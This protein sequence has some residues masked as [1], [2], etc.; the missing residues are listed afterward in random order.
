MIDTRATKRLKVENTS[1]GESVLSVWQ[2]F[3]PKSI[4]VIG[5]GRKRGTIG[6]DIL[7]NLVDYGFNGAVYPV[8]PNARFIQSMRAYRSVLEIPDPIDLAVVCVPK[9]L[10]LQA[11]EDCG[12]KDVKSLVM[13]TAGFSETGEAGAELERR[14]FERVRHY[15]MRVIGPNCMGISNSDPTVR[16]DATFAN[17]HPIEGGIGFLSQSGALGVAILEQAAGMNLGLSSFVSLGN[18]TDVSVDDILAYW[19]DDP[20]TSMALL[21]IESFGNVER[22]ARVAREMVKTKPIIA[23]KSGRT[24]AGARAASSHTASLAAT[25]VAVDALFESAGVLRVDTVEMLFDLAQ[26]F[27]KQPVLRDSR[28]AIMSNGGGP[29]ILATDSVVSHGLKMAQFSEQTVRQMRE[30]L[31]E[32][33]SLSNPV[34]MIAS[35][36]PKHFEIISEILLKDDNVDALIVLYVPPVSVDSQEVARSLVRTHEKCRDLQKPVFCCFMSRS[37]EE[38]GVPILQKANI[39]VYLFPESAVQSLVAMD[40]YRQY[41]ENPVGEIRTFDDVDKTRVRKVIDTVRAGK[42]SDLASGEV[43]EI[44]D[45]WKLPILK[46]RRVSKRDD[47]AGT[48]KK[49]GYPL[50][51]KIDA[52][53][54]SHKSDVGG[55]KLNLRDERDLFEAYD[56]IA[57]RIA[58]LAE[59][60]K[61]WGV[62]LEPM[63]AGG[64]EVVLGITSDPRVGRL[65]MVGMGG[66]YV[67]IL[68]DVAFRL[69]PLTDEDAREMVTCLRGFP[70]LDG[71]R[72]E[73]PVHL[74]TLY[75]QLA[76]LSALAAEFPEIREMDVN[77]FLLFAEADKCVAVDA[78]ISLVNQPPQE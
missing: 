56:D 3:N 49:I 77:P 46:P 12:R 63:I 24:Q 31:S 48:A 39:P 14:I 70:I 4:A 45:A 23:V 38:S 32:E 44:L 43:L 57:A 71:V 16:M 62:T 27:S 61:D 69:V 30:S 68:K 40:R 28:I 21:Y 1:E 25:D 18:R 15:G 64:R 41:R 6:R 73:P 22:F 47:L 33:A 76:R 35:A 60:P 19:K 65:V 17:T 2:I 72:G 34:D 67:E 50:V 7:H 29:A 53:E 20:R 52:R 58:G 55:V 10:A 78:R 37:D 74:D 75:A 13:I 42:R 59:K 66:I 11:V 9:D 26:A 8:N 54:I 5:A 36:T 51:M